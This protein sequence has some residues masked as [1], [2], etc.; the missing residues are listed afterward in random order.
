MGRIALERLRPNEDFVLVRGE[1][2]KGFS[3][4]KIKKIKCLNRPE[5]LDA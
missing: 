1:R 4:I 3:M 2:I 5:A